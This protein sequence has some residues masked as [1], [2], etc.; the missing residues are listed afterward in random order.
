MQALDLTKKPRP[1]FG[2]PP[3][4]VR[5]PSRG[6]LGGTTPRA[7]RTRL[8]PELAAAQRGGKR[9]TPKKKVNK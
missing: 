7:G 2:Q 6:A 3:P 5:K 9:V 8:P 1:G 4:P